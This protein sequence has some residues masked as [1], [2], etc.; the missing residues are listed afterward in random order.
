MPKSSTKWARFWPGEAATPKAHDCQHNSHHRL[1]KGDKRLA[2][3]S[4]RNFE[5]YCTA[6]AIATIDADI[7]KLENLKAQL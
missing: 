4:I 7:R 2:I 3:K 6:C 5:Y 1:Q